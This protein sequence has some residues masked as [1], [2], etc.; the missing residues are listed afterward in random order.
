[1]SK[2]TKTIAL[3][4]CIAMCFSACSSNPKDVESTTVAGQESTETTQ[5]SFTITDG[6]V[7]LP[8]NKT[9]GI[10]PF[11]AESYENIYLSHFLYE[12]LFSIDKSYAVTNAIAES[13]S[14]EGNDVAVKLRHNVL[15]NDYSPLTASDVVYSFNL[16]KN[17]YYWGNILKNVASARIQ[18]DYT[19]VFALDFKDIYVAGKLVFPIVKTGTADGR[20]SVPMGSGAYTFAN[21]KLVNIANA[22]N[23]VYLAEISDRSSAEDAFNIG[24]TDVFFDDLSNCDYSVTMGQVSEFALNNMVYLG[25]NNNKGAL[26][27]NIRSAIAAKLD[28]DAIALSSYQGHAKGNKLPVNP[29]SLLFNELTKVD[30]VGNPALA[31]DIIDQCGYTRY[32]G[33]AKTNG[34]YTLSLSLIV[35]IENQYRVAAAY[36]IADS[37]EEC[38]FKISIQILTFDE[39]NRRISSGDYDMYL[40]EVKLDGSMDISQFFTSGTAFSSGIDTTQRVVTEYFNYRAGDITSAEYYEIF[41]EYYPFIPVGFRTGYAVTSND[42]TLNLERIPFSL[43]NGI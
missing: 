13:I 12:S 34:S 21:D 1:M 30:S 4:L 2:I 10:N 19:V 17:S 5:D 37:L 39:Y 11:F 15:C 18:D 9:D 7:V 27:K 14:F 40:G 33:S 26:D 6:K 25:L 3:I 8:Y 24:M 20:E 23:V 42:V 32:S 16:A 28:A 43:Y 22:Q 35:N 38:G 41:V 36:Q 31:N 29:N